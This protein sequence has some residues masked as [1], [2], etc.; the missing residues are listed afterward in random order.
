[1]EYFD[2]LIPGNEA[3]VTKKFMDDIGMNEI[4]MS[5]NFID[6]SIYDYDTSIDLITKFLNE[7]SSRLGD[8][9]EF[10]S[11]MTD[12]YELNIELIRPISEDKFMRFRIEQKDEDFLIHIYFNDNKKQ[13]SVDLFN[14]IMAYLVSHGQVYDYEIDST[15]SI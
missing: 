13:V 6:Y 4:Y 1:M 3:I 8:E 14:N 7:F 2:K 12:K 9:L 15:I 11:E 10:N 5:S